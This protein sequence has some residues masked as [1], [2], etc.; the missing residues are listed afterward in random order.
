MNKNAIIEFNKKW[1]DLQ[2]TYNTLFN[3]KKTHLPYP[4]IIQKEIVKEYCNWGIEDNAEKSIDFMLNNE[5]CEMKST[6]LINGAVNFTKQQI[7]DSKYIIWF[8]VDSSL[9]LI[10]IYKMNLGYETNDSLCENKMGE[11]Y[12]RKQFQKDY[13]KSKSLNNFFETCISCVETKIFNML[14]MQEVWIINDAKEPKAPYLQKTNYILESLK[15]L[16]NKEQ[17]DEE[18]FIEYKDRI[19]IIGNH[20]ST[21]KFEEI[22]NL[23]DVLSDENSEINC[24]LKKN[25]ICL[26]IEE[27]YAI[28][29]GKNLPFKKDGALNNN[30][31]DYE[32]VSFY[33][34]DI[35]KEN[36][37]G[38][39]RID[40]PELLNNIEYDFDIKL[41]EKWK[42]K[43]KIIY[44]YSYLIPLNVCEERFGVSA[45]SPIVDLILDSDSP[46]VRVKKLKELKFIDK[47]IIKHH[48]S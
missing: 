28:N 45:L 47:N 3:N 40:C 25:K 23:K 15:K 11:T 34:C 10:F 44:N 24:F 27:K 16:T 1:L 12:Q 18:M 2:N 31:T 36:L 39:A 48:V 30:I 13:V 42:R 9:Q 4:E 22:K 5:P 38:S 26:S 17:I 19:Y 35:N 6:T 8:Y 14:T 21:I 46:Y 29:D 43:N 7:D 37:S 33:I 32:Y 41:V 20:I